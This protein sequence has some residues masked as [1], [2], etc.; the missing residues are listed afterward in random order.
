MVGVQKSD[1][2][3]VGT[4]FERVLAHYT[5]PP[6]AYAAESNGK[7]TR[8]D[9]ATQMVEVTYDDGRKICFNYGS[10]ISSNSGGGF[11]IDQP[12]TPN[13]L[14]LN[15]KVRK[16]DILAY[17]E[18]FFHLD[19]ATEQVDFKLGTMA[20]VAFMDIDQ[21]LEDSSIISK[22]L[23]EKLRFA[24]ISIR[25]IVITNR[26]TVHQCVNVGDHVRNIEPLITFDESVAPEVSSA[27]SAE[28]AQLLQKLNR[29]SPKAQYDG[30]IVK[31]D[32]FYKCQIT[33][34]VPSLAK[35]VRASQRDKN[36]KAAFAKG[37]ENSQV[38]MPNQP[39]NVDKVGIVNLDKD[40][41]ILRF[42][43]KHEVPVYAG[44]KIVI[45][46]SLKSV[47]GKV[48]NHD[49]MTEDGTIR[50]D[51]VMSYRSMMARIVSSP[52][53]TGVAASIVE[54]MEKDI[55]AIIEE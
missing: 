17:N 55:L 27:S 1:V 54:K 23:S 18:Q 37:T 36:A 42:Y 20:Y 12:M 16:G 51:A 19:P 52:Q 5:R 28:L 53:L 6:F 40:T 3:R 22:T 2:Y 47:C 48:L 46:S 50:V 4:G 26:T 13:N 30:E 43:I 44:S 29:A 34:M 7:I 15:R 41:V 45:S 35:I 14:R 31:I 49:M 11:Y 38:Y 39:L 8:L 9:D 21:T 33:D 24:P 10:T 25:E 32:A